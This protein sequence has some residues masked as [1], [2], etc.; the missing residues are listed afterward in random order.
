MKLQ[1]AI[2]IYLMS[3]VVFSVTATF[4]IQGWD[5]AYYLCADIG[6]GGALLWWVVYEETKQKKMV[7]PVLIF[8]ILVLG[9]DIASY[10]FNLNMGTNNPVATGIGFGVAL[11][12]VSYY[13]V[14][15]KK[16]IRYV[17]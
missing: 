15:G 9:W 11:L 1:I 10:V 16:V 8:S 13:V 3:F 6:G 4:G 17:Q 12:I 14:K 7:L 2:L 5:M